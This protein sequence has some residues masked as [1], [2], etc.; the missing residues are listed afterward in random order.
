[1]QQKAIN[2]H[3]G[4]N[5]TWWLWLY[6]FTAHDVFI[7]WLVLYSIWKVRMMKIYI[8]PIFNIKINLNQ[9]DIFT[10]MYILPVEIL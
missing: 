3:V 7:V 2:T 1:M 6:R 5:V 9:L 8:F 10:E 4:L